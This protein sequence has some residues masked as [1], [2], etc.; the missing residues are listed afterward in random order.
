MLCYSDVLPSLF[1]VLMAVE[2]FGGGKFKMCL[3]R[4]ADH[5]VMVV[6]F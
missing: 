4:P 2:G 3:D 1:G 6:K 5:S